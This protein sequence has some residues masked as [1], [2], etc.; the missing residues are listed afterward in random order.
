VS[1]QVMMRVIWF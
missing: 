1:A